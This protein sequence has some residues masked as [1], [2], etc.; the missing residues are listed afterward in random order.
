VDTRSKILTSTAALAISARPMVIVTGKFDVL[1]AAHARALGEARTRSGASALLTVVLPCEGE[2][3]P[4][5]ARAELAA[6]LRVVDY[7]VAGGLMELKTLMQALGPA[8]VVSLEDV[9]ERLSRELKDLVL[10]RSKV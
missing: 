1:R 8:E 7:V 10:R 3:L 2:L 4:Q 5:R 6:S 9:E